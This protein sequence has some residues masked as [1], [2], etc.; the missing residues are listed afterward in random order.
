MTA[1]VLMRRVASGDVASMSGALS[2]P[3]A[4]CCFSCSKEELLRLIRETKA[5]FPSDTSVLC[6][7]RK[8]ITEGNKGD[9]TE[10][11]AMK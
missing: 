6:R 4:S 8:S 2:L 11:R 7:A 10:L 1:S 5:P 3:A 9:C